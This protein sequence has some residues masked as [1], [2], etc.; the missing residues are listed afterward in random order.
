MLKSLLAICFLAMTARSCSAGSTIEEAI[1]AAIPRLCVDDF[2]QRE[3]ATEELASLPAEACNVLLDMALEQQEPE[4]RWRL[5]VAAVRVFDRTMLAKDKNWR[6]MMADNGMDIDGVDF[7]EMVGGS[8]YTVR[9]PVLTIKGVYP[10]GAADGKG[11]RDGDKVVEID[12]KPMPSNLADLESLFMC[13]EE[14]ELTIWRYD[15]SK[16][17]GIF[18]EADPHQVLKVKITVGKRE[19][20]LPHQQH[21]IREI[22]DRAWNNFLA[23]RSKP[24]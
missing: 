1:K 13:D 14:Y 5:R 23:G 20:L 22:R 6:M 16:T 15:A 4:A 24:K 17:S 18:M 12:G 21:I 11:I 2:D 9:A 3:A 10:E 19:Y 8:N 7:I